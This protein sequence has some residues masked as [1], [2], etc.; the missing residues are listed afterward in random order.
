MLARL[1]VKTMA[2]RP[3]LTV[4]VHK[5]SADFSTLCLWVQITAVGTEFAVSVLLKE[6]TD[7]L[8]AAATAKLRERR[9]RRLLRQ[10][11]LLKS[12]ATTTA[13]A[14]ATAVGSNVFKAAAIA[15]LAR[16]IVKLSTWVLEFTT[17]SEFARP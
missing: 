13:T 7:L 16:A 11:R 15:E 3:V 5:V 2:V 8:L 12:H 17:V 6:F 1:L 9:L 14:A 10:K 4:P